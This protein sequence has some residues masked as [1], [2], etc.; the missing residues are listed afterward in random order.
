MPGV[1]CRSNCVCINKVLTWLEKQDECNA[2]KYNVLYGLCKIATKKWF[3]SM[4]QTLITSFTNT[5][6]I[7]L[8]TTCMEMY[9]LLYV[10]VTSTSTKVLY[11]VSTALK[12]YISLI[13]TNSLI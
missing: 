2:Y 7:V 9:I 13:R 3:S 5:V 8:Q 1:S 6:C 11:T 12:P 10:K 4:Q